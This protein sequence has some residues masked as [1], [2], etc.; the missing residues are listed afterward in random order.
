MYIVHGAGEQYRA[1][2]A[3]LFIISDQ[4]FAKWNGK[5]NFFLENAINNIVS[6]SSTE[7]H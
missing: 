3:L 1:M 5:L 6:F 4:F 7:Y 2:V